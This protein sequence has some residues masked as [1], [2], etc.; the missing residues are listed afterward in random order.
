MANDTTNQ[1]GMTLFSQGGIVYENIDTN[2][3]LTAADSGV[4][5][6]VI[7]DGITI[8]LP[9]TVVGMVF[10]IRN[11]GVPASSSVGSGTGSDFSALV[12]IA[13]NASDQINGLN[14][15]GAD[16]KALLNTKATSKVGDFVTLVGDGTAGVGWNVLY[17][18]GIWAR[19]S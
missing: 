7:A 16:N 15:T 13:P 9:A 1:V 19:A 3:T 18:R 2:K 4:V 11:G 5:Q 10:T 14:V 12:T 8:T 6:N 17:A